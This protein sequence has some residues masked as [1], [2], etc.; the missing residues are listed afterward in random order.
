MKF[1]VNL[2]K[3]ILI[4]K[5]LSIDILDKFKEKKISCDDEFIIFDSSEFKK[6]EKIYLE[7]EAN[8]FYKD[9][10]NY[11]FTDDISLYEKYENKNKNKSSSNL[12]INDILSDENISYSSLFE[13]GNNETIKKMPFHEKDSKNHKFPSKTSIKREFDVAIL[14]K[15]YF[16]IKKKIKKENNGNYL[17]ILFY[18]TGDALIKNAEE[19]NGGNFLL[20]KI[21]IILFF[22]FLCILILINLILLLIRE[23]KNNGDSN[24]NENPESNNRNSGNTQSNII[25]NNNNEKA[26]SNRSRNNFINSTNNNDKDTKTNVVLIYKNKNIFLKNK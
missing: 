5:I 22:V 8:R 23:R 18:C 11:E 21:F 3:L 6:G 16:N 2:I 14:V 4:S 20:N 15:K 10:I 7:I 1:C 12:N 25:T 24:N 19:N 17:A 26:N 13:N 9:F